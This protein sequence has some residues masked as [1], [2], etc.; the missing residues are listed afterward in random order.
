[1]HGSPTR[2]EIQMEKKRKKIQKCKKQ[3]K[4]NAKKKKKDLQAMLR[5]LIGK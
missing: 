1:M 2:A 4:K 3:N 5:Y